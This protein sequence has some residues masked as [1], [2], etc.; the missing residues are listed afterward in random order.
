MSLQYLQLWDGNGSSALLLERLYYLPP[1][2][3]LRSTRNILVV[4]QTTY[5][6]TKKSSFSAVWSTGKY[7]G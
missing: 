1:G 7:F 4:Q 2:V 6:V 5:D 3:E